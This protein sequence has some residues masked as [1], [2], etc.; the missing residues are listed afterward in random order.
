MQ[1]DNSTAL[2]A[3][4]PAADHIQHP[5]AMTEIQRALRFIQQ[6]Q[7]ASGH[8]GSGHNAK[9]LLTFAEMEV[10]FIFF[11]AQTDPVQSLQG[12]LCHGLCGMLQ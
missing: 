9:L 6:E 1:R 7:F 12:R 8:D 10:V 4:D 3:M 11:T 2:G 5:V